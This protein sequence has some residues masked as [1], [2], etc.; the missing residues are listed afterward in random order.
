MPQSYFTLFNLEPR[1]ALAGDQLD[2][3]Y[4]RLAARV[5]PDRYAN[6]GPAEQRQ[7]LSLATSANEAYRTLK[8]PVLRAKYLLTLRG[9]ESL[10]SGVGVAPEFLVEQMEWREALSGARA[11][12]DAAELL[13]LG[14][15]VRRRAADLLRQL[16]VHL[17]T[18]DD[19]GAATRAVQELMFV[20]KLLIDIDDAHTLLDA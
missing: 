20:D 14:E 7:A 15:L 8:K 5:H 3:A 18:E 13:Q 4:R 10:D 6:S 9:V 19:H 16:E 17:D 12:R 2:A 11:A 1:F